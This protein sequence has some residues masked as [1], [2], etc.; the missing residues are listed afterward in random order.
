MGVNYSASNVFK[1]RAEIE[2]LRKSLAVL[3]DSSFRLSTDLIYTYLSIPIP[4]LL[5]LV[6][7]AMYLIL[8]DRFIIPSSHKGTLLKVPVS[9]L[10][11]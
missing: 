3:S 6:L 9:R 11:K 8:Y 5:L 1:G 7:L 10:F 2:K 4:S